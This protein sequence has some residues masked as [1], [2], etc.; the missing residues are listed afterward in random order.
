MA[1]SRRVERVAS[2]IRRE[3]SELLIGGIK[4]ERVN[5]G[6]VSVTTVEVAGDLQHCKIFVSV[7]GSDSDK[8][9][10]MAGLRSASAFV[11]GELS[12]RLKMRRTPEVVFVLDRG[13]EKG[14]TVL[15]LLN[16]LEDERQEKGEPAEASDL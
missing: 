16:R 5:Q 13:I 6:M 12:R 3:I 14:T 9:Q 7:F 2:L 4:D 10:A 11:K 1:Q 15:G 8:E